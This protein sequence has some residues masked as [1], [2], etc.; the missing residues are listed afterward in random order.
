MHHITTK[1]RLLC[2]IAAAAS[3]FATFAGAPGEAR[4]QAAAPDESALEEVIVTARRRD[5]RLQDVPISVTAFSGDQL[6]QRSVRMLDDLQTIAAGL[7]VEPQNNKPS[8]VQVTIRGQR[9]YGV[10]SAQ[11]PP[12]AFYFADAAVSPIQ[13]FNSALYDLASVQ[14]LKGPQGTLFGRNTTGGAVVVTPAK[15]TQEKEG[16][17][18]LR[19]GNYDTF[20]AQG[21]LNLPVTDTL[22]LRFAGYYAEHG[23][24]D[25]YASRGNFGQKT[26]KDRVTDLRFSAAWQPTDSFENYLVAYYGKL[27]NST[28]P[29][30]LVA[31][32][33]NSVAARYNGTGAFAQFPNVLDALWDGTGNPRKR[34][35][36]NHPQYDR[37]E[38]VGAVNTTTLELG[39]SWTIKNI[40]S[41]RRVSNESLMNINGV[42]IPLLSSYQNAHTTGFTEELQLLGSS[43]WDRVDLATGLYFSKLESWDN[44]ASANNYGTPLFAFAPFLTFTDNK[45]YAAYG[46]A[47]TKVTDKLSLTTGVRVTKDTRFIDYQSQ[48]S[49]YYFPGLGIPYVPRCAVVGDDGVTLPLTACSLEKKVSYTRWTYTLSLDY[50]ITPDLLVYATQRKGYRSGG[51]N[52]RAF[53]A[54]QRL[55]FEPETNLDREVGFK[56]DFKVAGWA[57]RL[58]GAYY[59]DKLSNLQKSASLII[60]GASSSST[61]NAAAGTVQGVDIEFN[62]SPVEG[63]TLGANYS[64]TKTNYTGYEFLVNGVMRDFSDR[65]FAGVPKHQVS[66]FGS[67]SPPIPPEYGKL[68]LSADWFYSS[69]V[70]I[71]E[72]YQSK[73]QVAFLYTPAQF[74][75]IPEGSRPWVQRSY[76]LLNFRAA[77]TEAWGKPVDVA[78]YVKNVTDEPY[79][80]GNSTQY[81]GTGP[82]AVTIGPPR[83]YGVEVTYHF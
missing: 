72:L 79:E 80:I 28:I 45:S 6:E 42:D 47:T 19:G 24:Y 41:Y 26:A 9:M 76:H 5:E 57:M 58:N 81:M 2:G 36:S 37:T 1:S 38:L 78:V 32:N 12:T 44:Q 33:P 46:Q 77:L 62:V 10:L 8:T 52:Q 51:F 71:N 68:T 23:G 83:T 4:A 14:V 53:T 82:A 17:L 13:G 7:K 16:A 35:Y 20:G 74:A 50:H 29:S 25:T 40:G 49:P 39:D 73:S 21:Y 60:N 30:T 61:F 3:A 34:V 55:P 69:S 66:I 43:L 59:Y 27:V 56:S 64:Y 11:D 48:T 15:P 18:T 70:F 22:A 75:L 63:L 54:S 31:V 65:E 67:Y